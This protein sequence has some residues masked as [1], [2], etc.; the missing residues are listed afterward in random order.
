MLNVLPREIQE[1]RS[2]LERMITKE[3]TLEQTRKVTRTPYIVRKR[4]TKLNYKIPNLIILRQRLRSRLRQRM[5]KSQ[6]PLYIRKRPRCK[7]VGFLE[8]T[9]HN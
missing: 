9:R 5:R 3:E 4:P 8:A 6:V 7:Y 2:S 1:I